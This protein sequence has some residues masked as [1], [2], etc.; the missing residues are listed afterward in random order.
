MP[1]EYSSGVI[2]SNTAR[3][4]H[5]CPVTTALLPTAEERPTVS[6]QQA[7]AALGIA[8]TKAYQLA[9][10]GDFPVACHRIGGVWRIP[11]AELRRFLK[12]DADTPPAA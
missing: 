9:N 1:Q 3:R 11:T 5:P 6:L 12:L 7:A 2:F 8:P 10:A 4:A